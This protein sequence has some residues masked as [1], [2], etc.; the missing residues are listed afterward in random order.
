MSETKSRLDVGDLGEE[1]M[2]SDGK[3]RDGKLEWRLILKHCSS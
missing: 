3:I 1:N 2:E